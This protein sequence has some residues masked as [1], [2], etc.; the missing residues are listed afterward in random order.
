MTGMMQQE[1]QAAQSA[2]VSGGQTAQSDVALAS[3][4]RRGGAGCEYQNPG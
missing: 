3:A 2:A 1:Q 4:T